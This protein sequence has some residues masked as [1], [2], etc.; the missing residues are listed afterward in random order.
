[1]HRMP[2]IA[3]V[4]LVALAAWLVAGWVLPAPELQVP[5]LA[6]LPRQA[7]S[8][9]PDTKMIL[10]TPLFGEVRKSALTSEEKPKVVAPSRLN[11][12]LIGTVVAEDRS[13]AVVEMKR[14]G[15]QELFFV[16]DTMQPGVRLQEVEVDAIVVDHGGRLERIEIEVEQML[17]SGSNPVFSASP[18]FQGVTDRRRISRPVLDRQLENFPQLLSQARVI[19][20][21][22]KGKAD[23]FIITEI[24]PGSLYEKAGLQNGDIIRKV[25]GAEITGPQQAMAMFQ[26][27]Q[28]AP[29]ISVEIERAGV[30]QVINY[31]IR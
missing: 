17:K 3:E 2:A 7:K 28:N 21:F 24:M 13:A 16:G 9:L 31:D 25:N 15:G 5:G 4:V 19:P 30:N 6:G 1:M 14:G 8:E 29:S 20:R 27:L 18:P 12:R 22:N 11:I 10:E 26:K 23:G